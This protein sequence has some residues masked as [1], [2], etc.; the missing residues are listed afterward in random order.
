MDFS[1]DWS[2][3]PSCCLTVHPDV[4]GDQTGI[5]IDTYVTFFIL[6]VLGHYFCVL[7]SVNSVTKKVFLLKKYCDW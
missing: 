1:W 4:L 6:S 7:S 3:R 2:A 5:N